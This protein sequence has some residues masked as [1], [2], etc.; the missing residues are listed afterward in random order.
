MVNDWIWL[1]AI[2]QLSRLSTTTI[3]VD[4]GQSNAYKV[5]SL[6]NVVDDD[7]WLISAGDTI[8]LDKPVTTDNHRSHRW[9]NH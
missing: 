6:L 1:N 5:Q 9:V 7:W 2:N 3:L 8:A 4:D